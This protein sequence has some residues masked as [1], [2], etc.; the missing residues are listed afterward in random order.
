[1]GAA[2]APEDEGAGGR[3]EAAGGVVPDPPDFR[4][5][6][7]IRL[8]IAPLYTSFEEIYRAALALKEIV[9]QRKYLDYSTEPPEV[10]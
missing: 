1:M 4:A 3:P 5:P 6:D 8:G 2:H 10:T 9:E 7:N